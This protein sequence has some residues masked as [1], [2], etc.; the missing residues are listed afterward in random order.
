MTAFLAEEGRSIAFRAD[1]A[2]GMTI[3]LFRSCRSV[4][5]MGGRDGL[6][7]NG[8]DGTGLI[9]RHS[10]II[11]KPKANQVLAHDGGDQSHH[12]IDVATIDPGALSRPDPFQVIDKE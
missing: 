8:Y 3:G 6:I 12:P 1:S 11:G 2:S 4:L 10:I 5:M 9:P 7:A